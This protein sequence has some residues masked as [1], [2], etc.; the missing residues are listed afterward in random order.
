MAYDLAILGDP[1]NTVSALAV[2]NT[3]NDGVYKLVQRILVLLFTD[4]NGT[5][6]AGYGTDLS[7][8]VLSANISDPEIVQNLFNLAQAKV[9]EQL[10]ETTALDAPDDEVLKDMISVVRSGSEDDELFVDVT[11]TTEAGTQITVSAPISSIA[12]SGD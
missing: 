11:I 9:Q 8:E 10:Q 5:G 2:D 4:V 6:S 7:G 1:E 3:A 12:V